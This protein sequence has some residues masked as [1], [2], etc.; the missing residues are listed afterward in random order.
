MALK[1]TENNGIFT[2]EGSLNTETS[3][4][5]KIHMDVLFQTCEE[6]VIN[7]DNVTEID[8]TGLSVLRYF[9]N[10]SQKENRSF[11]ITGYGCK[12]IY[13]DFRTNYAA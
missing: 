8:V 4:S 3:K 9:F 11:F 5:F 7:I 6:V 12:E 2:V 13:D 10:N 1:I